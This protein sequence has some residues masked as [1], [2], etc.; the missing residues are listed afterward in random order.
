[1]I[2]YQLIINFVISI[3]YRNIDSIQQEKG[4]DI[5]IKIFS[6]FLQNILKKSSPLLWFVSWLKLADLSRRKE[7]RSRFPV[8]CFEVTNDVERRSSSPRI[9]DVMFFPSE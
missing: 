2:N 5:E 1:L 3:K 7:R 4:E 9:R 6:V 8:R